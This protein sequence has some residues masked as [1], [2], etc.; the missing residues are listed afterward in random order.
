MSVE[1]IGTGIKTTITGVTGLKR[2]YAPNEMPGSINELPCAVV[3]HSGTEYGLAMGGVGAKHEFR[4][5][6]MATTQD[7]AGAFDKVLPFLEAS[8]GS[9]IF[10]ALLAD[11]TLGSSADDFTLV[12]NEGQSMITWGGIQYLGTAFNLEVY[13]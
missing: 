2:V 12:S 7:H 13:E 8:G 9:S 1:T 4:I 3:M 5:M 11:R 10:A 6:V